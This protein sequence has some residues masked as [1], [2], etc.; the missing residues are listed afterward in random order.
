MLIG[1]EGPVFSSSDSNFKVSVSVFFNSKLF[2]IKSFFPPLHLISYI[3]LKKD[4]YSTRSGSIV[5][6]KCS[7][8]PSHSSNSVSVLLP[9]ASETACALLPKLRGERVLLQ[10]R[11]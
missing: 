3:V 11:Q 1:S 7:L 9:S 5:L 6:L 4:K 10:K 2:P 8:H